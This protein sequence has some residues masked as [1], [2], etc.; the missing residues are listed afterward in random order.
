MKSAVPESVHRAKDP[1]PRGG[2]RGAR[3]VT[4]DGA[5]LVIANTER[6]LVFDQ[7]WKLVGDITHPLM[8]GVHDILAE[9]DG[10]WITCT[11]ADLLLKLDRTGKMVADWEW[12][13]DR[14]LV[15]G[16]GFRGLPKVD[17]TPDY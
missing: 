5:R 13:V 9:V 1:N 11:N 17:R 12:R 4:T 15:A 3:G 6:L 14:S 2:L 10:I 7:Y 16:F 8:G